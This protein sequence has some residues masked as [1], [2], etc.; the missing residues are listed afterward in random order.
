[1]KLSFSEISLFVLVLYLIPFYI[2]LGPALFGYLC[3]RH[4]G[5]Q[6]GMQ[7]LAFLAAPVVLPFALAGCLTVVVFAFGF[8]LLAFPI[9]WLQ[10]HLPFGGVFTA[11]YR[12]SSWLLERVRRLLE[13]VFG[14]TLAALLLPPEPQ[15]QALR[16]AFETGSD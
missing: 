3:E 12:L 15:P 2:F 16:P 5:G 4:A 14:P 7:C 6:K 1:M 10:V 11:W 9:Y 8:M 13:A